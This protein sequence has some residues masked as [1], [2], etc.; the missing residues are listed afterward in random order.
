[1]PQLPERPRG[2]S[3]GYGRS[4]AMGRCSPFLSQKITFLFFPFYGTVNMESLV[5]VIGVLKIVSPV[6]AIS[7]G[8]RVVAACESNLSLQALLF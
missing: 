2:I 1:M 5:M 4:G 8:V 7:V 6:R 3:G